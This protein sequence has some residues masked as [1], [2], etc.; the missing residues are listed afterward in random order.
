[1]SGT[2]YGYSPVWLY[3]GNLTIERHP[4]LAQ[5]QNPEPGL[6]KISFNDAS[7]EFTA[8]PIWGMEKD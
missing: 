1:V 2:F 7:R 4:A 8:A 5:N 3:H 6:I